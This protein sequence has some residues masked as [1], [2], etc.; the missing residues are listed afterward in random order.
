[1]PVPLII[2][3][4]L[5][6]VCVP[7]VAVR[8]PPLLDYPNHLARLWL[9]SGGID[10]TTL[11]QFYAADWRNAL[12]NG[13]MD[14]LVVMLAP[15]LGGAEP[16][17]RLMVALALVM[18][19]LGA[20][21]LNRAMFGHWRVWQVGFVIF[22]FNGILLA[23]FLSFMIGLG[24]ALLAAAADPVLSRRS[25]PDRL[26]GRA[27]LGILLLW[28]HALALAFYLALLAGLAVG[29]SVREA[30]AGWPAFRATSMRVAR[31]LA[32]AALPAF[33]VLFL[34]GAPGP[35]NAPDQHDDLLPP[36]RGYDFIEKVRALTT[37]FGT[38][39]VLLDLAMTL[40]FLAIARWGLANNQLSVHGGLLVSSAG[41]LTLAILLPNTI[42]GTGW[43]DRRFPIMALLTFL[44]AVSP[45]LPA[46][47]CAAVALCLLCIVAVRTAWI[48]WIWDARQ[49]DVTA[50]ERA[51]AAMPHGAAL[52][53]A[54]EFPAHRF[55]APLGR[56]IPRGQMPT[57]EHLGAL[58]VVR[59]EAFVPTLFT[60]RGRHV[61]RVLPPWDEVTLANGLGVAVT[62]LDDAGAS[63]SRPYLRDWR[64][65]FEYLLI[66]D[67]DHPTGG[68]RF[69]PT[70]GIVLVSD[71]GFARL[72]RIERP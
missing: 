43:M 16:A 12:T 9:L 40:S 18:P 69:A 46:R 4:A 39:D 70:N 47:H 31:T 5:A 7:V 71:E 67:G 52:L 10:L 11:A 57:Y 42:G 6:L 59:R 33:L 20:V 58:A 8:V 63:A 38:Y 45:V 64:R 49:P 27:A 22:A 53:V 50:V 68:V 66:L 14:M 23:G 24:A 34:S 65:R 51:T 36:W 62:Q 19:P 26:I 41:L 1:M 28:I 13:G 30:L 54:F 15:L 44:A 72:Y 37:A 29:P 32:I 60:L 35:W 55:S 17:M 56:Y 21:L 48:G 3:F 2:G 25:L 61:L